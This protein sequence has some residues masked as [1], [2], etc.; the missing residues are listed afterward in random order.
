MKVS[1]GKRKF[2]SILC[3]SKTNYLNESLLIVWSDLVRTSR[4][5]NCLFHFVY[6]IRKSEE[7]IIFKGN[8]K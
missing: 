2:L 3:I 6:V 1:L 5:Q 4:V 7:I 8:T